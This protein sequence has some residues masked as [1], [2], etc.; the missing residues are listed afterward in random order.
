MRGAA[1]L[2]G[3]E[4]ALVT[5]IGGITT[6]VGVLAIGF[7]REASVAAEIGGVRTNLRMPGSRFPRR[8]CASASEFP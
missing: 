5:D 6:D 2:S 7:P 3:L 1:F 4:D 8:S